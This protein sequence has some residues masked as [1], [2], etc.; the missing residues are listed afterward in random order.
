MSKRLKRLIEEEE[1]TIA[2]IEELQEHLKEIR[3]ARKQEEDQ[4][5]VRS[6]RTMKLGAR[7]LFS[8]LSGI[9]EGSV[10]IETFPVEEEEPDKAELTIG[11]EFEKKCPENSQKD[12]SAEEAP[13]S[14]V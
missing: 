6:I 2:K 1:R 12:N 14:E 10:A 4:E 11:D 7:E 13:E 8:L 3:I 9:Q 5:I